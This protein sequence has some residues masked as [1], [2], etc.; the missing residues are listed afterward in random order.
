MKLPEPPRLRSVVTEHRPDIKQLHKPCI[1]V[2]FVLQVSPHN[3]RSI[4]RTQRYR[5]VA[6]IRERVHLLINN[7]RTLAY[8]ALKKFRVL[9]GRCAYLL[10]AVKLTQL[11]D[12]IFKPKPTAHLLRQNVFSASRRIRQ[13]GLNLLKLSNRLRR[14]VPHSPKLL[15]ARLRLRNKE[16]RRVPTLDEP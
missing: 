8:A 12:F 11:T 5:P 9:K 10:I 16:L 3:R 2:K 4:F 7:V 15:R 6:A 13:Q 14:T 1:S